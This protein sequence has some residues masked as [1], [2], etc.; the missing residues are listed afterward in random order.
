MTFEVSCFL[1]RVHNFDIFC[2]FLF[3]CFCMVTLAPILAFFVGPRHTLEPCACCLYVRPG[4]DRQLGDG[5]PFRYGA[6]D[7]VE[8]WGQKWAI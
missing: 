3:T 2:I 8:F 4:T 5:T 7:R 1:Q 6:Y